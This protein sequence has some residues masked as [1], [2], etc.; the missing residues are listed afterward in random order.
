[1]RLT[2]T[3]RSSAQVLLRI[4][5]DL[6]DLS[7][8][9]A[10]KI[11]LEKLPIDLDQILD[12]CANL[13]SATAQAKGIRLSV[14][15]L[16]PDRQAPAGRTLVGDPF[17]IRQIVMNLVGNA[18]KFTEHGEIRVHA[19]IEIPDADRA[20]VNIAV[21]D[22]GIGMDAATVE[23]IFQP[24]T[25][26]DES[27]SRRFGGSGLGLAI[28][29]ELAELM[30]GR[31]TAESAPGAGSTFHVLL[32]LGLSAAQPAPTA[33]VLET[34]SDAAG[35]T[36][37]AIGAHVLLVE[38][39][40]VNAAVAQGYLEALGCTSVW[41]K[42]GA[43]A[44]ARSAAERFDLILMDINMPAFDGYQTARLIRERAGPGR[45]VPII[46]LTAH[47]PS[48]VRERCEAAGIDDVL[49]KPYTPEDCEKLLR[50]WIPRDRGPRI[51]VEQAGRRPSTSP[52]TAQLPA[53]PAAADLAKIDTATVVRL[54]GT[55]APGRT[56]LYARLV[57]LFRTGSATALGELE[58]AIR[59]GDL[60]AARATCHKLKSSAANVGAIAFSEDV[61]R[62][63]QLCA[64][65]ETSAA[66]SAFER[67]RSAHPALI[68]E[69]TG[70][71]RRE[72][73]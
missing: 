65:G 51:A 43:E 1:V 14:R 73:A 24:F 70:L 60:A 62:L 59:G 58:A 30:G 46:A 42:D 32:P 11:A 8:A 23:K 34:T 16:A 45:R 63:E 40:P 29:R 47:T 61:R 54:R 55:G 67:L 2:Q 53:A 25:Q 64:G 17:R 57:E 35:E 6:L 10:G 13:F 12:E 20:A 71:E 9:Q 27:T 3:I 4:V 48:Q 66:W 36:T 28:C 33:A 7:R 19:D 69:L 22:S 38:D 52:G 44:L 49:S 18:V 26:A 41:T 50:R 31:I 15:P 56:N 21:S 37:G 5:N 68:A 72:S 39:E